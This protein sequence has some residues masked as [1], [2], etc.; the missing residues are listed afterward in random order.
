MKRFFSLLLAVIVVGTGVR[1]RRD[2]SR[3]GKA[4]GSE[5][6]PGRL[7]QADG[8]FSLHDSL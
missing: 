3:T 4:D 8:R 2:E 6:R 7:L 5:G 1:P